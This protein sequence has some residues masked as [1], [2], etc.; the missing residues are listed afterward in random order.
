MN[1]CYEVPDQTN[2]GANLG[3]NAVCRPKNSKKLEYNLKL[4][5]PYRN[6]DTH[7]SGKMFGIK[8]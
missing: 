6:F 2:L 5:F 7:E 4:P 8:H 3:A 1:F